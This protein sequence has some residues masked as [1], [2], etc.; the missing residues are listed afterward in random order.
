MNQSTLIDCKEIRQLIVKMAYKSKGGH[1]GSSFSMVEILYTL[2]AFVLNLD[3]KMSPNRDRLILSSS[4]GALALYSVLYKKGY[5]KKNWIDN[6]LK[7]DSPL[8]TFPNIQ[9]IPTVEMSAGSLGHG[10]SFG[11]GTS[12]F[13]KKNNLDFKTYVITGDGELEEVSIWEA[14]MYAAHFKLDNLMLIINQ[15]QLQI[16]GTTEEI[17]GLEPLKD[18]WQSF[19][20]TVLECDGHEV[21]VLVQKLK[22]FSNKGRPTVIIANTVKGKGVS[23]MEHSLDWHFKVLSDQEFK[24]AMHELA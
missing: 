11:V 9:T 13:A 3:Q 21:D 14:A 22:H 7:K 5:L 17:M 18:K 8:T 19:G 10:L 20:W 23:F 6:F 1:I 16:D 12:L 2:Y 4:Q 15:N 24:E